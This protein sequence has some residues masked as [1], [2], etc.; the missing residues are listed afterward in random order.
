MTRFISSGSGFFALKIT[1]FRSF[2]SRGL[3][4]GSFNDKQTLGG[5]VFWPETRLVFDQITN[6]TTE[7]SNPGAELIRRS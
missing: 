6:P 5:K 3:A 2:L 1:C 4:G 7:M